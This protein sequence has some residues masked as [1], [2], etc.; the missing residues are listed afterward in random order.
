MEEQNMENMQQDI[1]DVKMPEPEKPKSGA[2]ALVGIIIIIIVLI[3]GGFYFL[4]S[5]NVDDSDMDEQTEELRDV[6][7]SDE[8]ADIE[9]D[10]ENTGL[11]DLDAEL[12]DVDTLLEEESN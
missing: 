2:G 6:T 4:G 8:V 11:E 12:D 5:S 1:G 9:T 7:D 3:L 10:L